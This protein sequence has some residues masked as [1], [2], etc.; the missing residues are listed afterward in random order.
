MANSNGSR[1]IRILVG[2]KN[3][4]EYIVIVGV[5]LWKVLLMKVRLFLVEAGYISGLNI[6]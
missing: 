1:L 4:S 3:L 2:R 5:C 6:L